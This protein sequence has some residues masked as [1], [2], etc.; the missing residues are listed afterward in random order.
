[1]TKKVYKGYGKTHQEAF[2]SLWD[3][4][5]F[6]DDACLRQ[7]GDRWRIRLNVVPPTDEERN[8]FEVRRTDL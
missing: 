3:L 2:E 4:M 8:E 5:R 7:E 6:T 1:M